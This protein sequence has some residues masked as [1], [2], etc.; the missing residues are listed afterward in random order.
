MTASDDSGRQILITELTGMRIK[1]HYKFQC[2]FRVIK[3][4]KFF[5]I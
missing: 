3:A 2:R 5:S 4:L 1:D